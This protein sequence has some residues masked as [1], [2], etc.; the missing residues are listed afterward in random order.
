MDIIN[1]ER[2]KGIT[3]CL[4]KSIPLRIAGLDSASCHTY[5]MSHPDKEIVDLI[6]VIYDAA[7]KITNSWQTD[8]IK[9]TMD[10]GLAIC[11]KHD[12][13]SKILSEV[14]TQF[15]GYDVTI[16]SYKSF[17]LLDKSVLKILLKTSD[18]IFKERMYSLNMAHDLLSDCS[19]DAISF[20][21]S[22]LSDSMDKE[23][24]DAEYGK[25][26]KLVEFL[27]YVVYLDTAYRDPFFW[28][29]DKISRKELRVAIARYIIEP[30]DWYVNV[31]DRS[32][33]LT[34]KQ[35]DEGKIPI[36][37]HSVVERRMVPAKQEHDL[38]KKK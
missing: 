23:L 27:L 11:C 14:L 33:I 15:Y 26:I 29:L 4:M 20:I 9:C 5:L 18:K 3:R 36:Y 17:N 12:K 25:C 35:R 13:Y 10:V 22:V 16:E 32:R 28:I 6:S 21:H 34:K 19:N 2:E 30:N 8:V 37:A 24:S 1:V 38:N 31:W 7:D